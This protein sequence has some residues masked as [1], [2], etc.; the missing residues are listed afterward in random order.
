VERPRVSEYSLVITVETPGR[1]SD[2]RYYSMRGIPIE[3]G[4][5]DGIV[6]EAHAIGVP[7]IGIGDGGNEAGMGKIR[8]LVVKHVPLG[9]RIASVVETDELVLSAVSNWGAY[10][11]VA[12]TS[13]LV[14]EDLLGDF[15]EWEVVKAL[16]DEG[17]ID[18]VLGKRALSVDGIPLKT[19]AK[20]LAFLRSI[21]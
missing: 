19:H 7:T 2:G 8:N 1:A 11:L 18:G 13:R 20:F 3:G 14:G 15:D 4:T 6:L 5:F 12:E 9:E 17:I 21:T 16:A 10:G